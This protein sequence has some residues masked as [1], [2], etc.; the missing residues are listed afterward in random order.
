MYKDIDDRELS[1]QQ[2]EDML[3]QFQTREIFFPKYASTGDKMVFYNDCVPLALNCMLRY[4]HF[5]RREQ[6]VR[7]IAS[8]K[9]FSADKA[10]DVKSEGGTPIRALL[11]P[12]AISGKTAFS[13]ELLQSWKKASIA[14]SRTDPARDVFNEIV[15]LMTPHPAR[16]HYKELM[17][18]YF[19]NAE[20]PYAH[21]FCF[22][23][24]PRKDTKGRV[25]DQ[26][27]FL[28]HY[29]HEPKYYLPMNDLEALN[30]GRFE[31][32]KHMDGRDVV[33]WDL[34]CLK[35][36]EVEDEQERQRIGCKMM[37]MLT[38]QKEFTR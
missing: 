5:Q 8:F 17:L 11:T 30:G 16:V 13:I 25:V 33:R 35:R 34:Y 1:Q 12:F 36:E 19:G 29:L 7:L 37:V 15:R 38:G 23:H 4:A 9:S 27:V 32:H 18:I 31:V 14:K 20:Y 10:G 28:D 2:V 21:A 22:L 24:V 26:I 6:I 3:E